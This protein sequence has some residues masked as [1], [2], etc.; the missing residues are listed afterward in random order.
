MSSPPPTSPCR[1]SV[2]GSLNA[3]EILTR[4]KSDKT[5]NV[6]KDHEWQPSSHARRCYNCN[7][8]GPCPCRGVSLPPEEKRR[9]IEAVLANTDFARSRLRKDFLKIIEQEAKERMQIERKEEESA[10][11][12]A[13]VLGLHQC[14]LFQRS[15]TIEMEYHFWAEID[16]AWRAV[17]D[18]VA[19]HCGQRLDLE[20]NEEGS[21]RDKICVAE[22]KEYQMHRDMFESMRQCL[23]ECL[24][25][26][27]QQRSDFYAGVMDI[28]E[29]LRAEEE[30]CYEHLMTIAWQL[31]LEEVNAITE[32][33]AQ[34]RTM[35]VE[36]AMAAMQHV[37]YLWAHMLHEQLYPMYVAEYQQRLLWI[38][39]KNQERAEVLA[40]AT[41]AMTSIIPV[42]WEHAL[43]LA[44]Q[45]FASEY[46]MRIEW[47]N[48]KWQQ[49]Q[50]FEVFAYRQITLLAEQRASECSAMY[51]QFEEEHACRLAWISQKYADRAALDSYAVGIM[52]GIQS[53]R[54]DEIHEMHELFL[55]EYSRRISVEDSKRADRISL[56]LVAESELWRIYN[57]FREEVSQMTAVFEAGIDEVVAV[58]K[59][60]SQQR[61]ELCVAYE[62]SASENVSWI[63]ATARNAIVAH[64]ESEYESRKQWMMSKATLRWEMEEAESF[65]RAAICESMYQ[66][67]DHVSSL[68]QMDRETILQNYQRFFASCEALGHTE[69]AGRLA[70]W[71]SYHNSINSITAAMKHSHHQ[72]SRHAYARELQSLLQYEAQWRTNIEDTE[73][74]EWQTHTQ[75][76]KLTLLEVANIAYQRSL[77]AIRELCDLE[78]NCRDRLADEE[79]AMV[80]SV[81]L[82]H[83]NALAVINE[84]YQ[85]KMG[86]LEYDQIQQRMKVTML[87]E[88]LSIYV[89]QDDAPLSGLPEPITEGFLKV[90]QE[91]LDQMSAIVF[92]FGD[93]VGH[94]INNVDSSLR[95]AAQAAAE[96]QRVTR[97]GETL[98]EQREYYVNKSITD[99]ATQQARLGGLRQNVANR[100]IEAKRLEGVLKEE[101]TY[102][103]AH[104]NRLD[105]IK[106]RYRGKR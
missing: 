92:A 102:L 18:L 49:R 81:T 5:R 12:L 104:K 8:L 83:S 52:L 39:H 59:Y 41:A 54:A 84:T 4:A 20:F 106:D 22:A 67:V 40:E 44:Q 16:A 29:D 85:R 43:N 99:G 76:L 73:N 63:E 48:S 30:S 62:T 101:N 11:L 65:D 51:H 1:P 95:R 24:M 31:S 78:M 50:D 26:Q 58:I 35:C 79:S 25:E 64:F 60:K 100:K 27:T 14:E 56:A 91:E 38:E 94:F 75:N 96:E 46:Q 17:V 28:T 2:L 32:A 74:V 42:E 89:T 3:N 66:S 103:E 34:A 10:Y 37:E 98:T 71:E 82:E 7:A 23:I 36:E 45:Q 55:E 47:I 80:E 6:D 86:Q 69:H 53:L 70:V 13:K 57:N 33:K 68:M 15:Q 87:R 97:A 90:S 77:L 21:H 105:E 61:H 88:S 19:L 72:A 9:R 93:H